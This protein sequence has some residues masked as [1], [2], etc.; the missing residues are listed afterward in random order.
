MVITWLPPVDNLFVGPGSEVTV[1]TNINGPWPT[2]TRWTLEVRRSGDEYI[3][4]LGGNNAATNSTTMY[5]FI[6]TQENGTRVPQW[7]VQPPRAAQPATSAAL[8]VR[9][10]DNNNLV[11]DQ[12]TQPVQW[13]PEPAG[14]AWVQSLAAAAGQG[15]FTQTDR[16]DLVLVKGAVQRVESPSLTG[17][18]P[19]ISNI[20]DLLRGPSRVLLRRGPFQIIQGRGVLPAVPAGFNNSHGIE[21]AI[22]QIPAG[23]GKDDGQVIEWHRR[24]GQ[25]VVIRSSTQGDLYIDQVVD[26]HAADEF[27]SWQSPPPTEVRYDL[28]PG[29]VLTVYWLV[30]TIA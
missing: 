24:L 11:I 7:Y 20:I 30:G 13:L 5:P 23:Y 14:V 12:A 6:F 19:V 1:Q 25:L 10:L 3:L 28:S 27:I 22:N 26:T 21:W 8:T 16:N 9:L 29:V 17:A 4:G 15:G 18:I 2:G